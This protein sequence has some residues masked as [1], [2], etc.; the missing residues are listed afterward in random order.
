MAK[1]YLFLDLL[2]IV[3]KKKEDYRKC[4]VRVGFTALEKGMVEKKARELKVSE[5]SLLRIGFRLIQK[6][7]IHTLL[8]LLKEK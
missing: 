8:D 1:I 3:R 2:L 4:P 7:K 5:S 6:Q